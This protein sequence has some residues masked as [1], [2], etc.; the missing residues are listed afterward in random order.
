MNLLKPIFLVLL[1]VLL[2]PSQVAAELI[3]DPEKCKSDTACEYRCCTYTEEYVVE[4]K[5]VAIEES[6]RCSDR[7]KNH[8]IGLYCLLALLVIILV[9]CTLMKKKE[10][11]SKRAA[12]MQ[13][14]IEQS[15]EEKVRLQRDQNDVNPSNQNGSER[16]RQHR[17]NMTDGI[18]APLTARSTT[19]PIASLDDV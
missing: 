12:L 13:L 16:G 14:K 5:C 2:Y 4:G 3:E 6:D 1:S 11:R 15:H 8:R 7:K 17:R 18:G 10:I 9:V 19:Q